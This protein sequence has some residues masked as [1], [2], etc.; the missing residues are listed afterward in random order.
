MLKMAWNQSNQYNESIKKSIDQ[1]IDQSINPTIIQ[2]NNQSINQS[3]IHSFNQSISSLTNH[4]K[5]KLTAWLR[6]LSPAN[7]ETDGQKNNQHH[8][9][10][11]R[12]Q[13]WTGGRVDARVW[14]RAGG[15][16]DK[17]RRRVLYT[18][19]W[20]ICNNDDLDKSSDNVVCCAYIT[21]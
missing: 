9:R 10:T 3:I 20:R 16:S 13:W 19:W 18:I 6:S 17:A 11:R 1:S 21:V 7:G 2:K 14:P 5:Y 8:S 4:W 12:T 15:S